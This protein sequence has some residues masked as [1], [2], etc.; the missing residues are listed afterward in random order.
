MIT[1]NTNNLQVYKFIPWCMKHWAVLLLT[2]YLTGKIQQFVAW[3]EDTQHTN[4][5][6][7]GY[8]HEQRFLSKLHLTVERPRANFNSIWSARFDRLD[9]NSKVKEMKRTERCGI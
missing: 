8:Q 1:I 2:D 7:G 5:H 9:D 4:T 3:E 6:K